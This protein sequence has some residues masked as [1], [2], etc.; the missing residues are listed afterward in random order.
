M[1]KNPVGLTLSNFCNSP[2]PHPVPRAAGFYNL[3]SHNLYQYQSDDNISQYA[4]HAPVLSAAKNDIRYYPYRQL[5][6]LPVLYSPI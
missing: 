1:V 2:L 4:G 3:L 5:L 6:R